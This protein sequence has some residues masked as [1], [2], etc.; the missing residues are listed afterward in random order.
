MTDIAT[1]LLAARATAPDPRLLEDA[2]SAI[3]QLRQQLHIAE[4]R[5]D[6]MQPDGL[7]GRGA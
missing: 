3:L 1:R 6:R 5:L 7:A 4:T 2:V